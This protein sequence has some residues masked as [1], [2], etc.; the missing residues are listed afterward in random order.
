MAFFAL[1]YD[2]LMSEEGLVAHIKFDNNSYTI[3]KISY[4]V[5]DKIGKM[6]VANPNTNITI[7]GHTDAN[8][9]N[10]ANRILG[11]KRADAVKNYL[12]DRNVAKT[13]MITISFGE[14]KPVNT[15]NT[16]K[17]WSMNRR[18]VFR[19]LR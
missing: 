9:T 13:R 1:F 14:E 5:L 7:A 15:A 17:A 4:P 11:Q 16:P 18:V 3:Q 2:K 6:L 12:Q 8:G 10:E 19:E